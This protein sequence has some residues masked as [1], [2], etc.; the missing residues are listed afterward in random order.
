MRKRITSTLLLLGIFGMNLIGQAPAPAPAKVAE[1][2]K[3]ASLEEDI[4]RALQSNSQVLVA[5]AEATLALA[6]LDQ[7]R[8]SVALKMAAARQEVEAI[9][10]ELA[11]A[12]NRLDSVKS[13]LEK[14]QK[15]VEN[16]KVPQLPPPPPPKNFR[17]EIDVQRQQ[18]DLEM[19]AAAAVSYLLVRIP[20]A[21]NDIVAAK[22]KLAAAMVPYDEL[23]GRPRA[24]APKVR[25]V[26]EGAA[27]QGGSEWKVR[28]DPL[29]TFDARWL[30]TVQPAP[31][32]NRFT[33]QLRA[34]V[35]KPVKLEAMKQLDIH[36]MYER[37]LKAA[38]V[39]AKVR[40][41][42]TLRR[43]LATTAPLAE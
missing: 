13:K 11:D 32:A 3:L 12:T 15:A 40:V 28:I 2:P 19:N 39:D 31:T 1:L 41:P 22:A 4:A 38:Q 36:Q 35:G 30:S 29:S 5:E 20:P 16:S 33:D 23:L 24:A 7:A 27:V 42:M 26:P 37:L 9:R 6:K 21:E 14:A 34:A 17:E 18:R 8:Q 25:L 43:D 10:K